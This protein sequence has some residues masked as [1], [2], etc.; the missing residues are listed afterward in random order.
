MLLVIFVELYGIL[1]S[2]T[3]P[4]VKTPIR[5]TPN[6][7]RVG[8][9]IVVTPDVVLKVMFV[10]PSKLFAMLPFKKSL[11]TTEA[12]TNWELLVEVL[13]VEIF[14]VVPLIKSLVNM[15]ELKIA[16]FPVDAL[17]VLKFKGSVTPPP[18]PVELIVV[19]PPV[20]DKVIFVPAARLFAILPFKKS[21]LIIDELIN[22]ILHC[23]IVP[24]V[25]VKVLIVPVLTLATEALS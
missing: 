7:E 10:P 9:S 17:R 3:L 23:P 25:E 11:F 22:P 20:V 14:A 16:I 1:T 24:V 6:M 8:P 21:P 5:I 18:P 15:D 4:G 19:T 2:V 13:I 12:L